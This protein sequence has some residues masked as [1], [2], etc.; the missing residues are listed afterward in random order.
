MRISLSK[1][2]GIW[3]R[4]RIA[5]IISIALVAGFLFTAARGPHNFTPSPDGQTGVSWSAREAYLA[6]SGFH[7]QRGRMIVLLERGEI[8]ACN[9]RDLRHVT[10]IVSPDTVKSDPDHSLTELEC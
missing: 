7:L 9:W 4:H 8:L 5:A 6:E 3:S 10:L 1:L 2:S